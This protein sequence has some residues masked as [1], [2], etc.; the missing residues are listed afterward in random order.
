M[1][2]AVFGILNSAIR[3]PH[4]EIR[5]ENGQLFYDNPIFQKSRDEDAT[6]ACRVDMLVG[7]Y[8]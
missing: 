3:N 5:T 8:N 7:Y 4:S 6:P 2:S 1:L